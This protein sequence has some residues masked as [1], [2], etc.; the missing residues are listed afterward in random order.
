MDGATIRKD[1]GAVLFERR[2]QTYSSSIIAAWMRAKHAGAP[3]TARQ[4][5][6][7]A[8]NAVRIETRV[9]ERIEDGELSIGCHWGLEEVGCRCC[10]RILC[11]SYPVQA[12]RP[13][14]KRH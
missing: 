8:M 10:E 6:Y 5:L 12:L 4:A 14:V 9:L 13:S 1:S 7:R 2:I 11:A 3:G